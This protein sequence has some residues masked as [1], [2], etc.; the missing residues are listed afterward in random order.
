M[1]G[2]VLRKE[3]AKEVSLDFPSFSIEQRNHSRAEELRHVLESDKLDLVVEDRG[4]QLEEGQADERSLRERRG[5]AE[6]KDLS[7]EF[8]GQERE[9][10]TNALRGMGDGLEGGWK[11]AGSREA[12]AM[13]ED[14]VGRRGEGREEGAAISMSL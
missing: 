12:D 14:E 10:S 11:E 7:F 5:I 2:G 8:D 4:G 1:E 3:K 6:A 9:G 13:S